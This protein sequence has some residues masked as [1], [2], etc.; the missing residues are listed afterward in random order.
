[1]KA[2]LQRVE[3]AHVTVDGN[4]I[5]TISRGL[6]VLLGVAKG[7][8]EA[9]V[10]YMFK[11]ILTL[12]IFDDADGVMNQ[13]VVDIHGALLVVPQFTLLADC[14][15]GRRPSFFPAAPPE[16][17][18]ML[19]NRFLESAEAAGLRVAAGEFGARMQ[20]QLVNNGPVTIILD[21]REGTVRRS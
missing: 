17:G 1:M 21:S 15:R 6:L 19:F 18:R 4:S 14:S 12:R 5:S 20:V 8:A 10:E 7:D 3:E 2:V 13:S 16:Q 11:K 9:D